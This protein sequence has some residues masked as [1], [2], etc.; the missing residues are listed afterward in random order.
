MPNA[1][2]MPQN[3]TGKL[4]LLEHVLRRLPPGL[5]I[6]EVKSDYHAFVRMMIAHGDIKRVTELIAVAHQKCWKKKLN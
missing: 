5:R 3:Q 2:F 4:E 1:P 6:N